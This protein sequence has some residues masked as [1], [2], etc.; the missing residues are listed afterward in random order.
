MPPAQAAVG[1]PVPREA[2]AEI[3]RI[4][5]VFKPD[6]HMVLAY[7]VRVRDLRGLLHDLLLTAVTDKPD[8]LQTFAPT[9]YNP[10]PA[11]APAPAPAGP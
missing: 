1:P 6:T 2:F 11:P 10:I 4:D 9:V 5:L 7:N 8:E 3:T